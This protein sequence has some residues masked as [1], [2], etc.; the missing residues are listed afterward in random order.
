MGKARRE[1]P[2]RESHQAATAR[3]RLWILAR[4]N[5]CGSGVVKQNTPVPFE[6]EP[7]T[8]LDLPLG[9]STF[10]HAHRTGKSQGHRLATEL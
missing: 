4:A 5:W 10:E 3:T 1:H 8:T 9:R 7:K 6:A 2:L